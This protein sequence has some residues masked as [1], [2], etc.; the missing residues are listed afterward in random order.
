MQ[1]IE[2]KAIQQLTQSNKEKVKQRANTGYWGPNKETH[3][4]TSARQFR[5]TQRP[6]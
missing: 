5:V 3:Q 2:T 6:F 4:G 1:S